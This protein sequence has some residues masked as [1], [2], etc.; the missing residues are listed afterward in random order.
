MFSRAAMISEGEFMN[1]TKAF[2]VV[3]VLAGPCFSETGF[4]SGELRLIE[5]LA[6]SVKRN[7]SS[8]ANIGALERIAEGKPETI[9]S[10]V[11]T[12]ASVGLGSVQVESLKRP[13]VRAYA[14]RNLADTGIALSYLS[15]L[16]EE[17]L[18]TDDTG[19]IWPAARS[20][21][22]RALFLQITDPQQRIEFLEKA[23]EGSPGQTWALDELCDHN[24]LLSLPK[25]REAIKNRNP[26][27][28]GEDEIAFCEGR[29]AV[30][31]RDPD[32]TKALGSVLQVG[33]SRASMQMIRWAIDQLDRLNTAESNQ[34]LDLFVGQIR[35]LPRGSAAWQDLWSIPR[36]IETLRSRIR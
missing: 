9:E 16:R 27:Q 3:A 11:L 32:R 35:Q 5:K 29:M 7:P 28:S 19:E 10:R 34:K 26:F 31:A 1:W 20:A 33:D 15:N 30:L 4:G 17:D 8:S 24:V 36:E 14:L 21:L 23:V 18:G 12:D 13:A 2:V 6:A 25:I 22:Q